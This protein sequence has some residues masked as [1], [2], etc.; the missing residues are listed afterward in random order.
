MSNTKKR[1]NRP[2]AFTL[3]ELILSVALVSIL[4]ALALPAYQDFR[5]RSENVT[6]ANN[7]RQLGVAMLQLLQ[8]NNNVIP[9]IESNPAHPVYAPEDGAKPLAEI[10]GPYGITERTLRCPADVRK[11][12]YFAQ[13]GSSYEWFPF[14]DGEIATAPKI[15]LPTGVLSA[16]FSRIPVAADF[17][18]VHHGRQNL[19]FADGHVKD[20]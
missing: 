5:A 17:S 16:A 13:A 14:I 1:S 3:I 12:N 15:Y 6:C 11:E 19:L 10:Y 2:D 8:D 20:Y 7:L 4:I 9:K 18:G